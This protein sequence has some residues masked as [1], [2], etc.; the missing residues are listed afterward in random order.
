VCIAH[1][2]EPDRS[3]ETLILQLQ[4]KRQAIF[5]AKK[6]QSLKVVGKKSTLRL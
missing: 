1:K 4:S 3:D 6:Q 5:R 2:V